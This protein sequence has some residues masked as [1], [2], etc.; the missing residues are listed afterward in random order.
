MF[1]PLEYLEW[2]RGRPEA[3][4]HDLGAS[5]LR[6]NRDSG[7]VVPEAVASR[8]DPPAGVT[9]E[10]LLATAY[11]VEPEHVLVTAG[12]SHANFLAEAALLGRTP[13]PEK[14]TVFVEEPGYEPLVKT[15]RALG[16][17]VDRF[18]RESDSEYAVEPERLEETLTDETAL[19]ILTNRHNPSGQLT[20]REIL[21][22]VAAVVA[23]A[24]ARLLVD[25]V[26][27]P[28]STDG[29]GDGPFGGVTACGLEETL[30]TGSLTKF[31]GRGDIQIGWLIGDPEIVAEARQIMEHVP[32][33]GGVNRAMARRLLYDQE[34]IAAES[35]ELLAG[36]A[37]RLQ[38]FVTERPHLS[39]PVFDGS[40]FG[41]L[42]HDRM[43]G[44]AIAER[45][46]QAGVL[47]VPGRFFDEPDR[48][49]MSLGRAETDT[50]AALRAFGDVLDESV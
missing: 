45:A 38:R 39:G 23:D 1:P 22:E 20:R 42:K 4:L 34:A 8:P 28:Y 7:T 50:E 11:G 32:T 31:F 33:V 27:A 41:F 13:K 37:D 26:Y 36:H 29:S 47:V 19:V 6:G 15:P 3:A 40:T 21:G 24:G 17:T 43:D 25:E 46:A 48:F 10:T 44:D 9:V 12:A 30:V 49:R 2:M 35:R 16:A 14:R 5:D 18:A